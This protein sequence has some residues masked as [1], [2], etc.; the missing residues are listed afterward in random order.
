MTRERE[1]DTVVTC[2]FRIA[3]PIVPRSC[4]SLLER[5]NE[6]ER[7]GE[8]DGERPTIEGEREERTTTEDDGEDGREKKQERGTKQTT[9]YNRGCNSK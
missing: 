9:N 7:I 4:F 6:D 5:G 8:D 3:T 2:P 1:Y